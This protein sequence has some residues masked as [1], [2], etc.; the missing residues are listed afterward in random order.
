MC[1]ASSG[2]D[3]LLLGWMVEK[4]R[5]TDKKEARSMHFARRAPVPPILPTIKIEALTTVRLLVNLS[6]HFKH[7]V[8]VFGRFFP[9]LM[10]MAER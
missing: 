9:W 1:N 3:S 6:S 7:L 4:V 8:V 2:E 10:Q 5:E